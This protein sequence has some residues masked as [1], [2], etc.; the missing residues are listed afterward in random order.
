M[1]DKIPTKTTDLDTVTKKLREVIDAVNPLL[2]Q[3][4][5]DQ[6]HSD[7]ITTFHACP[8]CGGTYFSNPGSHTASTGYK[9]I[10]NCRECGHTFDVVGFRYRRYE[11]TGEGKC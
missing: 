1:I 8:K 4:C 7:R 11:V 9:E 2:D 6:H 3:H 5:P 10:L